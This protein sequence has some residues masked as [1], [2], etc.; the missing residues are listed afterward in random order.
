MKG[1]IAIKSFKHKK[2]HL[3]GDVITEADVNP[4]YYAQLESQGCIRYVD[5]PTI[6]MPKKAKPAKI[7]TDNPVKKK[8]TKKKK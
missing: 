1:W 2:Q 7:I 8:P 3:I 4:M 5:R 6:V